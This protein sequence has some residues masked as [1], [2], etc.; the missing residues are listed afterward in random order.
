M[1][2]SMKMDSLNPLLSIIGDVEQVLHIGKAFKTGRHQAKLTVAPKS[3]LKKAQEM[4]HRE[5]V[6]LLSQ[7][8]VFF[9]KR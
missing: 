2:L 6:P 5:V 9:A 7:I 3:K 1:W 8:I 4:F